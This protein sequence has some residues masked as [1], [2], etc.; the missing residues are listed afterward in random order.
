VVAWSILFLF[1][2]Y[3]SA[4]VGLFCCTIAYVRKKNKVLI[5]TAPFLW[6]GL[7]YFR[8]FFLTG[9]PWENL[10]CSQYDWLQ[11]IQISDISGVYGVSAIIIAMNVTIFQG[12][13]A[14]YQK[15]PFPWKS[16]VLV[17][18]ILGGILGYG[19]WKIGKTDQAVAAAPAYAIAVVQ[20]NIDQSQKWLSSFQEETLR[21]YGRL[22]RS[23]LRDRPI[24]IIWPETALPF[25]FL[26]NDALTQQV[27]ALI[28]ETHQHYLLGSPSVETAQGSVK[29]YNSA[30]LLDPEG[31]V[32][33]RYDKVHLVPYGEYI[34]LKRFFPFL[35]KI[36]EAVGNFVSG[37]KGQVLSWDGKNIGTLICFEI[38]FPE[39]A[40]AMALNGAQVLVNMTND[41]WFGHSSAPHQHL[42]MAVFRAVE[43]RRALARAANTGISAFIDPSGR[44]LE[45]TP[46]YEEAARIRSLPL[47][48]NATFYTRY[49]DVFAIFSVMVSLVTVMLV[50]VTSRSKRGA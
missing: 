50:F 23:T 21:R 24:L 11:V 28:R 20:G 25:Y 43:T 9:F 26:R 41:A 42:S 30:Y 45:Q 19:T 36:T 49:G 2:F 1:V 7:E 10:G 12:L 14:V 16:L 46:L 38:I 40:R 22:T 37:K 35:G 17:C 5:W 31:N 15:S 3:L 27:L 18:L 32:L 33:E 13:D 39:L 29:Y 4:Y 6:A 47:M 34:P 8:A 44:I 48:T